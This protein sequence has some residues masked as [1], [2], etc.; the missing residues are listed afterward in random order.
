MIWRETCSKG[1]E[2]KRLPLGLCSAVVLFGTV[3][4]HAQSAERSSD[5]TPFGAHVSISAGK[6]GEALQIVPDGDEKPVAECDNYCDF[7]ALPGRYTLYTSGNGD[8]EKHT[9]HFRIKRS[10][11]YTLREGDDSARD[12]GLTLGIA[13]SVAIVA[14]FFMTMPLVLSSVCEDSNCAT[15]SD[16][17]WAAAGLGFMAAGAIA[18]PIGFVVFSHNRTKLQPLA[19]PS[20]I[21]QNAITSVR[22][23]VIGVNAGLALGGSAVF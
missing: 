7:W 20:Y 1:G 15:N 9:L 14:G 2:M 3:T 13:G 11:R 23:G 17:N 21:G 19:E 5:D 8:G 4:A 18:T 16:R 22:V 12:A 10:A 6:P